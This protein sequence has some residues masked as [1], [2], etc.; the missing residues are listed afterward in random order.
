MQKLGFKRQKKAQNRDK[1]Y[2]IEL[3]RKGEID[4][5]IF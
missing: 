3:W 5:E 1:M 2:C 4:S